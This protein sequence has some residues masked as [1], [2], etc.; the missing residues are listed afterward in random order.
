M[1]LC[2]TSESTAQWVQRIVEAK[3]EMVLPGGW[4]AKAVSGLG[5]E[6]RYQTVHG[7]A[8][9]IRSLHEPRTHAHVQ[10][11]QQQPRA[12]LAMTMGKDWAR[13]QCEREPFAQH[14]QQFVSQFI[15]GKVVHIVT[16]GGTRP[17]PSTIEMNEYINIY[18]GEPRRVPSAPSEISI[19]G[20]TAGLKAI[21]G[22]RRGCL[23]PIRG[24]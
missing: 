19:W 5:Q 4:H 3:A 11:H 15:R 9:D 13:M 12:V 21:A 1:L 2:S 24:L 7:N 22:Q 17:N 14:W 8:E 10:V 23:A 18:A 20:N 6:A 16:D